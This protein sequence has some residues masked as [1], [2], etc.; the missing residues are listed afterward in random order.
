MHNL[1]NAGTIFCDCLIGSRPVGVV[2]IRLDP[3]RRADRRFDPV[4]SDVA[5]ADRFLCML[6]EADHSLLAVVR[7]DL[8][9][10]QLMAQCFEAFEGAAL[11][12]ADQPRLARHIGGED[13]GE[14]AGLAHAACPA[15][16]RKPDR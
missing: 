7:G 6:G 5:C 3:I 2:W 13:R 1:Q 4:D 9:I 15:A 8:R 12:G 14:A 11:V 10:D 16:R